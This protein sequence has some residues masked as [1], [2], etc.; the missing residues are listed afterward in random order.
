MEHFKDGVFMALK[1][2]GTLAVGWVVFMIFVVIIK[3]IVDCY[4]KCY[5]KISF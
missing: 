4:N 5:N 1:S 2:L 3:V